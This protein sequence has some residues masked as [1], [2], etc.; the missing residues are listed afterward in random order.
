M[1]AQA[2]TAIGRIHSIHISPGGVPKLPI[3]EAIITPL[4]IEGDGH[5]DWRNHGGPNAALCLFSLDTIQRLRAEGHP[6]FPGSVGENL[7]LEGIAHAALT[8]GVRLQ[9]GDVVEIEVTSYTTPCKT[10]A[11]SFADGDFTRISQKVHPGQSRLYARVIKTGVL[12]PGDS[13]RLL[14]LAAS[15]PAPPEWQT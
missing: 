8:P 10:I 4:G 13:A 2:W 11:E 12:R 1:A 9:L 6:I 15:D 5:N 3:E 7:T 14:T